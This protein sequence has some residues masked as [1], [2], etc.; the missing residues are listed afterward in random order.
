MTAGMILILLYW[1]LFTVRHGTEPKA[2]Q[3]LHAKEFDLKKCTP[4][5][6]PEARRAIRQLKAACVALRVTRWAENA[7]LVAVAAWVFWLLGAII[8]G[9][10]VVLGYPV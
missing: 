8:T 9:T 5:E 4:D 1:A 3:R 10:V 6:A 7:L 2:K